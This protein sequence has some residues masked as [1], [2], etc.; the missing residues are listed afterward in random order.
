M[1]MGLG[2]ERLVIATNANDILPRTFRD[3]RLCYCCATP[4]A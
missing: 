2:I 3:A 1:H 4:H